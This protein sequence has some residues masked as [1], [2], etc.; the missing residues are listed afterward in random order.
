MWW[1]INID[2]FWIYKLGGHSTC[3][4]GASS[5]L[6]RTPAM[7]KGEPL[8]KQGS[9]MWETISLGKCF[10]RMYFPLDMYFWR[11]YFWAFLSHYQCSAIGG[12]SGS[13]GLGDREF[14]WRMSLALFCQTS[15]SHCW[16]IFTCRKW[17]NVESNAFWIL[18]NISAAEASST[19]LYESCTSTKYLRTRDDGF[20]TWKVISDPP[21]FRMF[22]TKYCG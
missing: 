3:H 16:I 9:K 8:N 12:G 14:T 19:E 18:V 7:S 11:M 1:N 5:C 2:S 15:F 22:G 10:W 6:Q 21:Y 13:S 4:G 17:Q 20:K